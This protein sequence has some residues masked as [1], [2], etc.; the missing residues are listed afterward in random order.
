MMIRGDGGGYR[1]Q[2]DGGGRLTAYPRH[3]Q[4]KVTL[5]LKFVVSISI[6]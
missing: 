6:S 4:Q 5:Y 3:L 2:M 1:L